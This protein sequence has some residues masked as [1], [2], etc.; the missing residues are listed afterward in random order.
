MW[1]GDIQEGGEAPG[2]F[3]PKI[4]CPSLLPGGPLPHSMTRGWGSSLD[5][6]LWGQGL[7]AP[8]GLLDLV[9][10]LKTRGSKSLS[11]RRHVAF[12]PWD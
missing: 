4:L 6:G 5:S 11:R 7:A 12:V 2:G 8:L 9:P 3:I 1:S 10:S